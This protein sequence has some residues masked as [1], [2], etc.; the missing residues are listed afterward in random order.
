VQG[1]EGLP[2]DAHFDDL[3]ED[4]PDAMLLVGSD[5]RIR[6]VNKQVERVFG[7]LRQELLGQPM[8]VLVPPR[9]RLTH[10]AQ[11]RAY[12]VSPHLRP[13]GAGLD[14]YGVRKDGIEFPAEISLSPVTTAEG[15]MVMAAVRDVSGRK[16]ARTLRW[17]EL[18]LDPVRL[19]ASAGGVVLKLSPLEFKMASLFLDNPG[20][21]F[22]REE[23]L[24]LLWEDGKEKLRTVDARVKRLR[25]RLGE[26]GHAIETVHGMGYRLRP[27]G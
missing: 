3:L 14:L 4:A 18:T 7:Y 19:R 27:Q 1:D 13:M 16:R 8:E 12:A 10:E 21:V 15:P 23:L 25:V 22:T 6:L 20:R 5:G 11:R 9:F 26:H 2:V 24:Q 17:K